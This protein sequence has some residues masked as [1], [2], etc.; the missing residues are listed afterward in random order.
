MIRT[1]IERLDDWREARAGGGRRFQREGA[2]TG[3]G[4]YL[5][6]LRRIYGILQINKHDFNLYSTC[7]TI[8]TG[9]CGKKALQWERVLY[10]LTPN[11]GNL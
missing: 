6:S 8:I 4:Y 5:G 3:K 10:E 9:N 2:I 7:C 11:K 1:Y